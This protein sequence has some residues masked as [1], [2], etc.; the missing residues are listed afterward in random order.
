VSKLH[1]TPRLRALLLAAPLLLGLLA[2]AAHAQT[3]AVQRENAQALYKAGNDA[4]DAGDLKAAAGRYRSALSVFPTPVIA[5]ALGKVQIAMGQLI[6][7][8]QTLLGVA[9]IPSKAQE[10]TLTM[11]ARAEAAKL[12][13]DVELRIPAVTLRLVGAL[14]PV[15]RV[16]LAIDGVVLPD[17]ALNAPWK[18]NP[19]SH[20]VVVTVDGDR[21]ASTFVAREGQAEDVELE[22]PQRYGTPPPEPPA[23]PPSDAPRAMADPVK[24]IAA[25][26]ASLRT[27][28]YLFLGVGAVGVVA[29]AVFGGLA[30][31]DRSALLGACT[32]GRA[33]CPSSAAG[34]IHALHANSIGADVA[35]GAAALGVGMGGALLLY[36]RRKAADVRIGA[37]V[38]AR[39]LGLR[40]S[41]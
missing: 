23:P 31:S 28:A 22:V 1:L 17:G 24:P 30:L 21:G 35:I 19:G 4:R 26:P 12:A 10:S 34:D 36:E 33:D 40:G 15:S 13:A 7:G 16:T 32:V 5:V 6:E 39:E 14:D 38:G 27:P 29:T 9:G 2:R 25:T 3:E 11:G 41:F 20:A 18:V 37:W 8:R